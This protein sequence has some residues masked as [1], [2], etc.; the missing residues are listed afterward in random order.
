MLISTAGQLRSRAAQNML[1]PARR[2]RRE[3]GARAAL[4]ARGGGRARGV[5]REARAAR[6]H[7]LFF[8]S[9]G[10]C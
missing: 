9:A 6:S 3:F 1:T 4:G 2:A 5:W 8:R 10:G 7:L